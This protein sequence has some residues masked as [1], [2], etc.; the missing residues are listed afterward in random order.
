MVLSAKAEILSQYPYI[1]VEM[2]SWFKGQRKYLK[3]KNTT[4]LQKQTLKH[5]QS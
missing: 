5:Y 1:W 3:A 2:Y 4:K